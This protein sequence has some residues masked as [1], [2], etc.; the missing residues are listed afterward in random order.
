MK[1]IINFIIVAII[2]MITTFTFLPNISLV[3]GE[4]FTFF[5]LV[6]HYHHETFPVF[7]MDKDEKIEKEADI[8]YF[9]KYFSVWGRGDFDGVRDYWNENKDHLATDLT[10]EAK[11]FYNTLKTMTNDKGHIYLYVPLFGQTAYIE[12]EIAI[13]ENVTI[14]F[15]NGVIECH[16]C[17]GFEL[18]EDN[19]QLI[20]DNVEICGGYA[21]GKNT[22][23]K[24]DKDEGGGIYIDGAHCSVIGRNGSRI[25]NCSA[26]FS[27]GG[28]TV[29]GHYCYI[30]DINFYNCSSKKGG[31][32]FVN[33]S[34]TK[35]INCGFSNTCKGNSDGNF[36]YANHTSTPT[37]IISALDLTTYTNPSTG[38]VTYAKSKNIPADASGFSGNCKT[39]NNNQ[40]WIDDTDE[41]DIEDFTGSMISQGNL[42]IIIVVAAVVVLAV[43]ALVILKKK[44]LIKSKKNV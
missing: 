20:L 4:D 30:E 32:I 24:G 18:D 22:N 41:D 7:Y 29:D 13:P 12:H 3:Y 26:T 27:G 39:Y 16:E 38:K 42:W 9:D 36:V 31:A 5:D 40:E 34:F 44:G 14:K 2:C 25:R 1:K 11:D 23:A 43:V 6:D 8:P 33:Y 19:S 17:R 35:I 21:D 28:I 15:S 37:A 10:L